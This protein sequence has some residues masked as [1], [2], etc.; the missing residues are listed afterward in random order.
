MDSRPEIYAIQGEWGVGKTFFWKNLIA[1]ARVHR[2]YQAYS[3][4]SLFGIA[5]V[6][7]LK[8]AIVSRA[9]GMGDNRGQ[10]GLNFFKKAGAGLIRKGVLGATGLENTEA[11]A[12]MLE[13]DC[14]KDFVVC[15]DDFE[16][17]EGV[18]SV[19]LLGFITSLRDERR[20]K[21]VMLYNPSALEEDGDAEKAVTEYREKVF[22]RELAFKPTVKESYDIIFD[23]L[24]YRLGKTSD[25]DVE[26]IFT[27]DTRSILGVFES[28]KSANIRVMHRTRSALDYFAPHLRVKYRR[29]W[30]H[31]ARQ[32][33]KLCC[34]Y[35]IHGKTVKIEEITDSK[36]WVAA[37][38]GNRDDPD[39]PAQHE[40]VKGVGYSPRDTDVIIAD[41]L[42][43]GYVAWEERRALLLRCEKELAGS[44]L[45]E[46]TREVWDIIWDNFHG[47]PAEFVS[48]MNA[49]LVRHVRELTLVDVDQAVGVL[50]ELNGCSPEVEGIRRRKIHELAAQVDGLEDL[51]YGMGREL[52]NAVL[53][54]AARIAREH[55]KPKKTIGEVIDLMSQS[56]GWNPR[57]AKHLEGLTED[58]F[59]NYLSG[60]RERRFLARLKVARERLAGTPGAEN[61]L[62]ILDGALRRLAERNA[63]DSRRVR[64]GLKMGI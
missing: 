33:V 18:S 47:K 49:F 46:K 37:Q 22:D 42:T 61:V 60:V 16:R 30:P 13:D 25:W 20:C 5:S 41:Y 17:M 39:N 2:N 24:D 54:E 56:G 14:L 36:K 52:S 58:D 6:A 44:R 34:I 3:Y 55:P 62:R 45:R 15:L 19:A 10:R 9:V 8:R 1:T 48:R 38:M 28:A 12:E 23:G 59:F 50:R 29:L 64:Y 4:V 27:P 57:D 31:F 11:W 51:S 26:N 32:V 63:L 43:L 21:V 35:Y 40:M 7:E 53:D